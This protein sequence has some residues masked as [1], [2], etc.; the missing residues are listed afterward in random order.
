SPT[1]INDGRALHI[2]AQPISYMLQSPGLEHSSLQ[3]APNGVEFSRF[4]KDQDAGNI[5]VTSALRMNS[6]F[7][8]IMPAVSLPS[9]P[10]IEV[11]DAGIRDNYGTMNS[12]QFMYIFRNWI[13]EN[14]SGVVM[15][16]IRDTYKQ[17]KVENNSVK[18]IFEKMLAPMRNVSGNFIIMQD[19]SFDRYLEYA[20]SFLN[21]PLEYILFQMPETQEKISLSWH[22]T[23]KEKNFLKDAPLNTENREA[24]NKL[25]TILPV[26][27]YRP[28]AFL[29]RY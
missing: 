23:E 3:Q 8:Y 10:A 21:T 5:K 15:I 1:I 19:Y 4:F 9:D 6:A 25:T 27:V 28:E 14:T 13:E 7:P 18:T 17:A 26:K 24:L 22:L 2:S 29:K 16:Q 12:V 20:S 11:M